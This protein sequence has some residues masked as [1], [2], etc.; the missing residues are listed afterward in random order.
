MIY[1]FPRK[2]N[3]KKS[4]SDLF[5]IVDNIDNLHKDA[6]QMYLKDYN[7]NFKIYTKSMSHYL[8]HH[9]VYRNEK[10]QEIFNKA[11]QIYDEYIDI[12]ITYGEHCKVDN[13]SIKYLKK[14]DKE[15]YDKYVKYLNKHTI[16]SL[17]MLG[18]KSHLMKFVINNNAI[19]KTYDTSTNNSR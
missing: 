10:T 12:D 7:D 3:T 16:I 13:N 6:I 5:D 18:L 19:V 2:I 1:K 14:H 8:T 15:L 17:Y 11:K 4:F 9:Y